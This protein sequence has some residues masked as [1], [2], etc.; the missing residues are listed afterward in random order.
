M[1]NLIARENSVD[2][3]NGVSVA[4]KYPLGQQSIAKCENKYHLEAGCPARQEKR[5]Q[6]QYDSARAKN[7]EAKST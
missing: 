5:A 3:V 2:V 4:T 1:Y 7:G 6:T